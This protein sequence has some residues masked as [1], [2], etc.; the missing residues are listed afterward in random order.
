ME[1]IRTMNIFDLAE[2]KPRAKKP[3]EERPPPPHE[4]VPVIGNLEYCLRCRN[5]RYQTETG[6]WV[7]RKDGSGDERRYG[8]KFPPCPEQVSSDND[9]AKRTGKK[10]GR[11]HEKTPILIGVKAR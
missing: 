9:R 2:E 11:R 1:P 7:L 6:V 8:G 10:K 4:W 3:S 5:S